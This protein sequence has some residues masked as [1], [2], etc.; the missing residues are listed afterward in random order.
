L[1]FPMAVPRAPKAVI[2]LML[3]AAI[4]VSFGSSATADIDPASDVL[5]LQD[6]FLPYNPKVCSQLADTLRK[7][8]KQ[9]KDNG[10]PLKVAI[11]ASQNDLGG[12][13]KLW[14]N[15]YGY[16][17]FLGQELGIYGP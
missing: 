11:I 6:V 4:W 16:S 8:T 17:I 7:L 14:G 1:W 12:A 9:T 5:L 3:S 13:T 15:T 10:F 2:A